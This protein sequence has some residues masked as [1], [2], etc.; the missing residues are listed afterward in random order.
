MLTDQKRPI[1]NGQTTPINAYA[2]GQNG[3]NEIVKKDRKGHI[4]TGQE[5]QNVQKK[6][7]ENGQITQVSVVGK[8]RNGPKKIVKKGPKRSYLH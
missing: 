7:I 1:K 5:S 2:K 6:K 3:Q 8:G 4:R